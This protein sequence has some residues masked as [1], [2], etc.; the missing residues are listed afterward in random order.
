MEPDQKEAA[1][2][3][4][5]KNVLHNKRRRHDPKSVPQAIKWNQFKKVTRDARRRPG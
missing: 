4:R 1:P 2:Q 5:S 3:A